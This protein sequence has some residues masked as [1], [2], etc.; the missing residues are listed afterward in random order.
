LKASATL[1]LVPIQVNNSTPRWVRLD[2][3][4]ASALQWVTG[5]VRPEACTKRVAVALTSFSIPV[6]QTTLT[7]GAVRF[8]Q[9]PTDLQGKEIFPGQK[10]LLG[11]GLLSRFETVT[12]DAIGKKVILGRISSLAENQPTS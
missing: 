2:T 7:L 3:G 11:N 6:T 8:E 5:S 12:I 1:P 10:G 4:C 9:V